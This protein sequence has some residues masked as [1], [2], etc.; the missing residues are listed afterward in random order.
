AHQWYY[1]AANLPAPVGVAQ[2][3]G[4]R[5]LYGTIG[6]ATGVATPAWLTPTLGQVVRVSDRSGDRSLTLSVQMRK[7]LGDRVEL[8]A[9][10]AH[11]RAQDR[12]CVVIF[13]AW[14][15]LRNAP[16]DGSLVG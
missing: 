2:G 1:G 15:N 3:E 13:Q 8:N 10:Y 7:R 12:M 14:P 9:L 4:N 16:R 11:T 5:P 6:A